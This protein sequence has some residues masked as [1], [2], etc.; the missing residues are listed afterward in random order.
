MGAFALLM[1]CGL[2]PTG[3]RLAPP[4]SIILMTA[5]AGDT[6]MQQGVEATQ[7]TSVE[8]LAQRN[9]DRSAVGHLTPGGVEQRQQEQY[10]GVPPPGS[11]LQPAAPQSMISRMR[12]PMV[13]LT[14]AAAV[15]ATGWQSK[16]VYKERQEGLLDEYGATMV[17]YLGEERE[18]A[19]TLKLFRGQLGPGSHSVPMFVAFIKQMAVERPADIKTIL[20]LKRA[21]GLMQMTPSALIEALPL[22]MD[23]LQSQPSMLGKLVFVAERAVPAAAQAAQ[24]R[25]KFPTWSPETV[26]TLQRAMLE[27]LYREMCEEVDA[28]SAENLAIL[29]LTEGEASR[30]REDVEEKKAAAAAAQAAVEE[31]ARAR[32]DLQ[33]A[34]KKAAEYK[35]RIGRNQGAPAAQDAEEEDAEEK[36]EDAPADRGEGTHEYECTKCGY[37]M[38]PAAGREFKFYGDDFSCPTCGADKNAFVDNGVVEV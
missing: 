26:S 29:G 17:A 20:D 10:I 37:I 3:P 11:G 21:V 34:V 25:S 16:K 2:L 30:L 33:A 7:K 22:A 18:M 15:F 24:L 1:S 23:G 8:L 9:A 4:R 12:A 27:N 31:E 19:S 36:D 5:A 28:D 13:G 14:L 6:S 32:D 35:P 38:F